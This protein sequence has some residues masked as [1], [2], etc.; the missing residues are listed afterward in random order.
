PCAPRPPRVPYPTLF[1]STMTTI[2]GTPASAEVS[3]TDADS[4]IAAIDI[5]SAPI[6]GITLTAT[7]A[8]TATLDV[9]GSV[10]I[11]TYPIEITFRRSEEHTSELQ[12][13]ANLV[14]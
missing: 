2:V 6:D 12:S 14:C 9:A 4:T 1:R 11:G 8:G 3:A 13:R 5:T 7:D 10:A